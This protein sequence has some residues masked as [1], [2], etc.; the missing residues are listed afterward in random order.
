MDEDPAKASSNF[1][2]RTRVHVFT[3]GSKKGSCPRPL[4]VAQLKLNKDNLVSARVQV[5]C[6]SQP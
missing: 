4:D 6:A 5:G 1:H 3:V 2:P